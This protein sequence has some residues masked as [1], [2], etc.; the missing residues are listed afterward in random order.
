MLLKDKNLVECKN[1]KL[2]KKEKNRKEKRVIGKFI[3]L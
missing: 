1:V 2:C 3:Y